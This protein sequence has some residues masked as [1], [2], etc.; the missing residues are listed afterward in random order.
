MQSHFAVRRS[1]ILLGQ[2]RTTVF[3]RFSAKGIDVLIVLAVYLIGKAFYPPLGA[4]AATFFAAFQD[5][6]GNGQSYGKRIIGLRVI[7]DETG[8]SCTTG[9]ALLRNV[10]FALA[11]VFAFIPVFWALAL[12]IAVPIGILE[13][14]LIICVD[15]GVRLG[16]VMA[17]TLVV[18]H[19]EEEQE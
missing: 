12:F 17:N 9:S 3:Q 14:Y 4:I 8:I 13:C 1:G 7:D 6:F 10:P 18:E 11:F 19:Q 2:R 16:D 15:S 5:S